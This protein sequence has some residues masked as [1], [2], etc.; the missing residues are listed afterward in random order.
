[1]LFGSSVFLLIQVLVNIAAR[2]P[3]IFPLRLDEQNGRL[4]VTVI[5]DGQNHNMFVTSGSYSWYTEEAPRRFR[6]AI[7]PVDDTANPMVFDDVGFFGTLYGIQRQYGSQLAIGLDSRL[8]YRHRS[9]MI[10]KFHDDV[11][12]AGSFVRAELVIGA[13]IG[14]FEQSCLPGTLLPIIPARS[15]EAIHRLVFENGGTVF[16][17]DSTPR[18]FTHIDSPGRQKMSLPSQTI[19]AIQ[20]RLEDT[21]SERIIASPIRYWEDVFSDCNISSLPDLVIEI[22][23][24][25]TIKLFPEDYIALDSD[26]TCTLKH[27]QQSTNDSIHI[28]ILNLPHT[29]ILLSESGTYSLCQSRD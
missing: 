27:L 20:S 12:A 5:I 22:H 7:Q 28:D 19:R 1:M 26:G 13:T 14:R 10:R 29:N 18:E 23:G 8:L 6:F 25:F 15:T 17:E 16:Y 4:Y 21:G 24:S 11:S 3:G 2:S 9:I